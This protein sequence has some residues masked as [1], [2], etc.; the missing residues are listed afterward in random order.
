MNLKSRF[1][2]E[3]ERILDKTFSGVNIWIACTNKKKLD[4]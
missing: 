2:T 1:E 3:N 4:T